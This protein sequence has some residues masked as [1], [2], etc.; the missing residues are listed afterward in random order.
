MKNT[1]IELFPTFIGL[2]APKMV[3]GH[4]LDKAHDEAIADDILFVEGRIFR[5]LRDLAESGKRISIRV[6]GQM[7]EVARPR[8]QAGRAETKRQSYIYGF[9]L[10]PSRNPKMYFVV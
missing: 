3:E 2:F 9:T 7:L 4:E 8:A 5:Q 10:K 1:L 6:L